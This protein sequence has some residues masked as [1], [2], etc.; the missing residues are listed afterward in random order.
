MA[1]LLLKK[2]GKLKS[3]E[4]GCCHT[5]C[6][7]HQAWADFALELNVDLAVVNKQRLNASE[8]KICKS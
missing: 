3:K 1:F 8:V 7:Q 4:F 2:S 6:W 5:G